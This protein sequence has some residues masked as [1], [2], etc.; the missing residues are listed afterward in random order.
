MNLYKN[1]FHIYKTTF[2]IPQGFL[3]EFAMVFPTIRNF[4]FK[5]WWQNFQHDLIVVMPQSRQSPRV[6]FNI[7]EGFSL[8]PDQRW[9]MRHATASTPYFPLKK[10]RAVCFEV[11]NFESL[12]WGR[13]LMSKLHRPSLK[14][15]QNLVSC[16][17]LHGWHR[18]SLAWLPYFPGLPFA[19]L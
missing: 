2:T 19:P 12:C 6:C 9:R 15:R 18:P 17:L 16:S 14:P 4:H 8:E 3:M 1:Y 13:H 10:G 11:M 5:C 7:R